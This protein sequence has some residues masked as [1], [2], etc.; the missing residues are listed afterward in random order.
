MAKILHVCNWFDPA[1]DV[2]R[3]VKE[4][5]KYSKYEHRLIISREH[6]LHLYPKWTNDNHISTE[7]SWADAIIFH[8][9]GWDDKHGWKTKTNKPIAFRNINI[10]YDLALDKFWA[11]DQYN[12]DNLED[13]K[14]VSS[15]HV[16]AKEFLTGKFR[17]LPDLIPIYDELYT[18]FTGDKDPCISFTKH[19][20]QLYELLAD[21]KKQVLWGVPHTDFLRRR[22]SKATVVVDNICDGHYGLAGLESMSM[23]LPTIVYNHSLTQDALKEL[24]PQ[25]PPFVEV[26]PDLAYVVNAA[27]VYAVASY[28]PH[29]RQWVEDMYN[30]ERIIKMYWDSFAEELLDRPV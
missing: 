10:R 5:Q 3:C 13:Y 29:I 12:A 2:V 4:L 19:Y 26:S 22:R 7:F 21:A 8:F 20:E 28:D 18:P 30:P 14:L 27:R 23:G 16:G 6:P 9:V 1:N 24:S 17:W 11:E 25:Y 15:S